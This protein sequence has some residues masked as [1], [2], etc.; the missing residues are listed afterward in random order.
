M[1]RAL[2]VGINRYLKLGRLHT[3]A[4]DANAV[5]QRLHDIGF[6]DIRGLP[7]TDEAGLWVS[8]DPDKRVS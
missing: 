3:P 1:K 6:E 5:A 2:V 8:S 7:A 4:N